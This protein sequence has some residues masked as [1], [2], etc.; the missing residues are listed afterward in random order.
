MAA[1]N[2]QL[3][4]YAAIGNALDAHP[5]LDGTLR[6]RN[7]I[8]TDQQATPDPRN[9]K[10]PADFP[11]LDLKRKG[12]RAEAFGGNDGRTLQTPTSGFAAGGVWNE[13]G[14]YIFQIEIIHGD[15]GLAANGLFESEVMTAL[16]KAG[17]TLGLAYVESWGFTATT[18]ETSAGNAGGSLREVTTIMI[19]VVTV[20]NG[21]ELT[22]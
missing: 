9:A 11:R 15:F 7:L 8:R 10:K 2:Y 6:V 13:S 14:V 20:F 4:I 16:H 3:A 5:P 17:P 19:E 18:E 22:T 21:P 1:T 12:F